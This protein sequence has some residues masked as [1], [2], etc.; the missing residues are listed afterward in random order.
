MQRKLGDYIY[1]KVVGKDGMESFYFFLVQSS[2]HHSF[3]RCHLPL[4][5]YKMPIV[6]IAIDNQ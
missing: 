1:L 5:Y 4:S 2:C 6:L 3:Y